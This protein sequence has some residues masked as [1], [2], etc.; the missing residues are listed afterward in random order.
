MIVGKGIT[1]DTGGLSLKPGEADG[2]DEDRHDGAAVALGTVLGAAEPAS[3]T[4]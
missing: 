4:R 1:Y 3:P 2:P